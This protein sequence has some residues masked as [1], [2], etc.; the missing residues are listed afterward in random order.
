VALPV[1]HVPCEHFASSGG[2][3][4][5][6]VFTFLLATSA[7]S[8]MPLP[9]LRRASIYLA[10]HLLLLS[11]QPLTLLPPAVIASNLATQSSLPL[12]LAQQEVQQDVWRN[13]WSRATTQSY[14]SRRAKWI[15]FS[16]IYRRSPLDFSPENLVDYLTYLATTANRGRPM[17]W[18]SIGAYIGFLGRA[19]SFSLGAHDQNPV[20]H[21]QVQLFLQGLARRMGKTLTKAEPCSLAHL[22]AISRAAEAAPQDLTL[23]TA[24]LLSLLAFWGCLRFGSLVPKHDLN[25]ALCLADIA[26]EDSALTLTLRHSKTIQF[27]ERIKTIHLPARDDPLLCPLRA[28]HQWILLLRPRTSRTTFNTLSA[29]SGATLSRSAFLLLINRLCSPLPP[30]TAHSFR[31]GYARLALQTGIPIERLMWHADWHSLAVAMSYGEDF[32][33]PNPI[34]DRALHILMGSLET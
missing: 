14:L 26:V 31:R 7:L 4:L 27:A 20:Q 3:K 21:P 34:D 17:S 32:M 1:V 13:I 9:I 23:A 11:G 29:T 2:C 12:T 33:I 5:A 16:T 10:F 28:L 18:S 30:L 22:R 15:E 19:A 6:F 24:R 8:A 25:K